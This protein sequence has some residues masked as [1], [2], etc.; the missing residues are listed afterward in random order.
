MAINLGKFQKP[1]GGAAKPGATKSRYAGIKANAPRPPM[2]HAGV[3]RFRCLGV[4]TGNNPGKS[5][6][7]Y[8]MSLEFVSIDESDGPN[9]NHKIGEQVQA[10]FLLNNATGLG[11]AKS[12]TMAFAGFE[13]EDEYNAFDLG[14]S[15]LFMATVLGDSTT[16]FAKAGV[17]IVGRLVDC[18]VMRGNLTAD[19]A[20]YYR[21]YA[22]AVV[23]DEEQDAVLRADLQGAAAP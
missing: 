15:G 8:K 2:P 5:R 17:T 18:M 16:E 12:C 10:I 3:Y 13:D 23:P 21:E 11:K 14:D 7:S 19:G 1:V 20:D 4:E 9:Q 6:E 22:W